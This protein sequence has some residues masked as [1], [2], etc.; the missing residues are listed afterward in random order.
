MRLRD[1]RAPDLQPS[2]ERCA[3]LCAALAVCVGNA[4]MG[5]SVG[6]LQYRYVLSLGGQMADVLPTSS[7]KHLGCGEFG[8]GSPLPLGWGAAPH[9]AELGANPLWC[10]PQA[11][12]HGMVALFTPI[13]HPE[14]VAAELARRRAGG[15]ALLRELARFPRLLLLYRTSPCA[16]HV[17]FA[18]PYA[19]A[20]RCCVA[21]S[22]HLSAKCL[23][24]GA[25]RIGLSHFTLPQYGILV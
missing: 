13:G 1:H 20:Y 17:F 18:Q 22:R 24:V 4:G 12:E 11:V 10:V 23:R 16:L 14:F 25:M 5:R 6:G 3:G 2:G 21:D 15:E 9:V 7:R 8:Q 19:H